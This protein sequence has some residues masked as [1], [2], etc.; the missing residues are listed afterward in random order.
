MMTLIVLFF[1]LLVFRGLGVL[2]VPLFLTW[3]DSTLWALS[4]MVLFTASAHFTALKEDLIK[5]VPRFFSRSAPDR[6]YHR[7]PGDCRGSWLVDPAAA[8]RCRYLPGPLV[9][10]H[11]S[12]EYQRGPEAGPFARQVSNPSLAAPPDASPLHRS[13]CMDRPGITEVVN[14]ATPSR[15]AGTDSSC[16]HPGHHDLPVDARAYSGVQKL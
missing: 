8:N 13:R 4:M 9:R 5:M 3:H 10:G 15:N 2:G 1:S 12:G 14:D 16:W 7:S 11:V 6:F